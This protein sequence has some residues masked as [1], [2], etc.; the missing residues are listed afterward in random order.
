MWKN[1]YPK[2]SKI[3]ERNKNIIGGK[4]GQHLQMMKFFNPELYQQKL[5]AIEAERKE[6]EKR[7]TIKKLNTGHRNKNR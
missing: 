4:E 7:N 6:N 5:K 3:P 1:K 2:G